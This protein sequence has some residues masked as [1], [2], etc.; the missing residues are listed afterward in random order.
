MSGWRTL[1]W[2][3]GPGTEGATLQALM[4]VMERLCGAVD[5]LS[6]QMQSLSAQVQSQSSQ[7]VPYME[8]MAIIQE[9]LHPSAMVTACRITSLDARLQRVEN[10]QK[11]SPRASPLPPG[12]QV[13]VRHTFRVLIR[14]RQWLLV[15][16]MC[17]ALRPVKPCK[18]PVKPCEALGLFFTALRLYDVRAALHAV[19]PLVLRCWDLVGRGR[20]GSAPYPAAG[21]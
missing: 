16:P 12:M 6:A 2:Y 7:Y 19:L 1:C 10:Q 9:R 8:R 20:A 5:S 14:M 15:A 18:G 11:L 17:S 13:P 4:G 3:A 21:A